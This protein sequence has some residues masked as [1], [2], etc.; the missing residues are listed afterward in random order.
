MMKRK[1]NKSEDRPDPSPI[2]L[3]QA[4]EELSVAVAEF[5]RRAASWS[6]TSSKGD[7][8]LTR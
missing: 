5:D 2:G 6:A 3:S 8:V 7:L 1:K 4:A